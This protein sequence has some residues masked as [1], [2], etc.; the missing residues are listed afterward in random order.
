MDTIIRVTYGSKGIRVGKD[1][2]QSPLH[3]PMNDPSN[4]EPNV[5]RRRPA[6]ATTTSNND[7]QA[8][9]ITKGVDESCFS[10]S[11]SF[12]DVRISLAVIL[13]RG[14]SIVLIGKLLT[15]MGGLYGSQPAFLVGLAKVRG[16]D[17]TSLLHGNFLALLVG[18]DQARMRKT[19]ASPSKCVS[20]LLVEISVSQ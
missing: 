13:S 20:T 14:N 4:H 15:S 17:F 18:L 7:N 8:S 1:V 9:W 6:T 11:L 16:L 10:I 3:C 2:Q 12:R 5:Q 19:R